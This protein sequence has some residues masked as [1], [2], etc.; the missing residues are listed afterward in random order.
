MRESDDRRSIEGKHPGLAACAAQR[1][2]VC[3]AVHAGKSLMPFLHIVVVRGGSPWLL[4]LLLWLLPGVAALI[5]AWLSGESRRGD[6]LFVDLGLAAI[7]GVAL[8]AALIFSGTDPLAYFFGVR[9]F[10]TLLGA[11]GLLILA[12]DAVAL[13]PERLQSRIPIGRRG[14]AR[15]L[16][17]WLNGWPS[18][19]GLIAARYGAGLELKLL[20]G[21]LH[22]Q[23]RNGPLVGARTLPLRP[24]VTAHANADALIVAPGPGRAEV[25]LGRVQ[26]P[27]ALPALVAAIHE[28]ARHPRAP[29]AGKPYQTL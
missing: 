7:G 17:T 13:L 18:E 29:L 23:V 25:V 14:G 6:A 12:H 21:A 16:Y 2:A 26:P 3:P 19:P 22:Y 24:E 27:A 4:G 1:A 11:F 8:N 28:Q 5:F 20:P 10:W 9:V 15:F